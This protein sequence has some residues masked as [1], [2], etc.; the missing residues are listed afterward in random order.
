M[1]ITKEG[2]LTGDTVSGVI[3]VVQRA[4]SLTEERY[5]LLLRLR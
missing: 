2:T 4:V 1:K 3:G 5:A